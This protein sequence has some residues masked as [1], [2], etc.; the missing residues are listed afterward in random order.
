MLPLAHLWGPDGAECPIRFVPK[1]SKEVANDPRASP[2]LH[3]GA[4]VLIVAD[5]IDSILALAVAVAR[6]WLGIEIFL[7]KGVDV[8]ASDKSSNLMLNVVRVSK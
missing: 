4:C 6:V 2:T 3:L 8:T 5:E 7:L 1:P